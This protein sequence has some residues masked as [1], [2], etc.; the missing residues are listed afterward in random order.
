MSKLLIFLAFFGMLSYPVSADYISGT[1]NQVI[2]IPGAGGHAK[3]GQ[4]DLSQSAA[5]KNQLPNTRGGTGTDSSASTGIAHVSSGT[6]SYSAVNLSNSD[7]TGNLGVT[8]LNSGT[9]ASNSTFWR[10]DGTWAT[11]T[12]KAPTVQIFTSGSAQT[13]TL[14]VA[15]SPLFIEVIMV[16][17]GG[18]GGGNGNAAGSTNGGAG[19]NSIFG[20]SLLSCSGGAGGSR[21]SV[22]G[23]LT[24]LAGGIGGTGSITAPAYGVALHGGQGSDNTAGGGTTGKGST[25]GVTPLGGG[26]GGPNSANSSP[27]TG[28]GG[29]GAY[30]TSF[31]GA[32]GGGGGGYVDAFIPTPSATYTYTVGAAGTAGAAGTSG[33]A[34]QG[35]SA[36]IIIVKEFYQ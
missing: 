6:W 18:G 2:V 33:V 31:V 8:H 24:P 16:G 32:A 27:N 35:G 23:T 17:G 5:T 30:D 1:A 4:V 34:G 7:V 26:G 12:F 14:P 9:G 13:Y 15:P 21:G 25:G 11:V 20:T 19:G 29:G 10:G 22:S 28:G 36:G 3:A